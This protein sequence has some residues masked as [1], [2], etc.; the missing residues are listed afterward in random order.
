MSRV[1]NFEV[2]VF[3]ATEL[4][5]TNALHD[6]KVMTLLEIVLIWSKLFRTEN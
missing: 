2:V 1:R 5:Q 3:A 4:N 6:F